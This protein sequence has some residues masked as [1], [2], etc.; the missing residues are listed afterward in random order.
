MPRSFVSLIAGAVLGVLAIILMAY[1]VRSTRPVG[2]E[3]VP[4]VVSG[5]DF[6]TGVPV[7]ADQLKV[8][9]WPAASVPDGAFVNIPE[10]FRGVTKPED[11]MALKAIHSG[12]PILRTNVS[13]F[14]GRATL[15]R[16]VARGMR[17][18]SISI[19]DVSGVAGFILPGDHVDVMLTRQA[20]TGGLATDII[21]QNITVLGIDQ[22]SDQERDKP[23]VARTVTVEVST[24]QAQKLTLAQ[25]AG[26]LSLALRNAETL[27]QADVHR[28]EVPDLYGTVAKP[29]H[30]ARH[31]SNP[32]PACEF[33]M[34][35]TTSRRRPSPL[36]PE[37][38]GIEG[39]PSLKARGEQE[40]CRVKQRF[41]WR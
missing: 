36:E 12:E 22:L 6:T 28:V 35:V 5:A 26:T 14:G 29:A 2:Q 30:V 16:E 25:Q 34:A 18:V 37:R 8:A 38:P 24:D 11:R 9:D 21:L 39:A 23:V 4:V 20:D 10:I 15:S 13:G 32:G 1:Y 7:T 40:A 31:Y 19:N 33:A 3:L 41:F 17:A 27:D